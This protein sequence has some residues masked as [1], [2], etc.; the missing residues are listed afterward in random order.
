MPQLRSNLSKFDALLY[1]AMKEIIRYFC[2]VCN[3]IK[4]I[5][6]CVHL[7][8]S[9]VCS[10]LQH[11][12]CHTTP[13]ALNIIHILCKGDWRGRNF[14]LDNLLFCINW[15]RISLNPIMHSDELPWIWMGLQSFDLWDACTIQTN[16]TKLL[17][18]Y[19]TKMLSIEECKKILNTLHRFK[20]IIWFYYKTSL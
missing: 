4:Y 5:R 7:W 20:M 8:P 3:D 18:H 2:Y 10:K 9:F 15:A 17:Y 16:S 1:G 13:F 6:M 19:C 14:Y 11:T 12:T